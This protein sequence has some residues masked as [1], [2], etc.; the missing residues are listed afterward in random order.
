[1]AIP[2]QTFR[3][4]DPEEVSPYGNL[5]KQ[6]LEKFTQ[7]TNA[8]FL[9]E[10][11][12]QALQEL[13]YKNMMQKP[14]AEHAGEYQKAELDL[15]KLQ[16]AHLQAGTGNLNADTNRLNIANKYAPRENESKLATDALAR[17]LKNVELKYAA[18]VAESGLA[19]QAS[20]TNERNTL[21]PLKVEELKLKNTAYPS[22]EAAKTARNQAYV[23]MYGKG[24]S[25]YVGTSPAE[26]AK[27]QVD[28]FE[29]RQEIKNWDKKLETVNKEAQDLNT[30]IEPIN[31]MK[32]IYDN[33]LSWAE[34]GQIG[35]ARS[36]LPGF[37]QSRDAANFNQYAG[38]VYSQVAR[39]KQS[40]HITEGNFNMFRKMKL[41]PDMGE[42]QFA[43]FTNFTQGSISR[44]NQHAE[45]MQTA[46]DM[47]IPLRKAEAAWNK[48]IRENTFFDEKKGV[49]IP[50]NLD[51]SKFGK[52]LG[53]DRM[54]AN[55]L[56][57]NKERTYNL[58]SGAFE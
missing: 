20:I 47:A 51:S 13:I 48:Y 23:D 1:M 32:E 25:K 21:N 5:L 58:E 33:N 35:A 41:T 36:S 43:S 19:N 46:K 12:R 52:Y 22:S 53:V 54:K 17:E 26:K 8:Q 16:P 9:P 3:K 38:Q 50:E 14:R 37:M 24:G 39:A 7:R 57:G 28:A 4:L 40:G 30:T 56:Q 2:V 55:L 45:F 31:K 42:K 34:K 44:A 11:K 6:S 10:E 27:A 15:A 18:Q 49:V 29:Q